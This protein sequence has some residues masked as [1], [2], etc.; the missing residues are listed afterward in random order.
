[1]FYSIK[2]V[3]IKKI[4]TTTEKNNNVQIFRTAE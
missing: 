3:I 1:M 4:I 2:S